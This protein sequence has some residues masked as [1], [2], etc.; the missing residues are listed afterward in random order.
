MAT[1][2]QIVFGTGLVIYGAVIMAGVIK[3]VNAAGEPIHQHLAVRLP[4]GAFVIAIG[5]VL[6]MSVTDKRPARLGGRSSGAMID[7]DDHV[8]LDGDGDD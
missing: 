1:V 6:M 2:V 4:F 5:A 3:I 8:D 7:N